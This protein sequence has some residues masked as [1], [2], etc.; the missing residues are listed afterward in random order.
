MTLPRLVT[1]PEWKQFLRLG[2]QLL[3]RSSAAA[4]ADL[5]QETLHT[6][7]GADAILWLEQPFFPLPG[8]P[9]VRLYT[10]ENTP[11][12]VSRV[13]ETHQLQCRLPESQRT[14][15]LPAD[16]CPGEV[17]VPL[18]TQ[19]NLL[20]ILHISRPHGPV[21]RKEEVNFLEALASHAALAMQ[22]NRQVVLK[23]WRYEQIALVSSV[24]TQIAN[25]MEVDEL[26]RR[27]TSLIQHTFDY[28]YVTIFTLTPQGNALEFRASAGAADEPSVPP[29]GAFTIGQ[30]L[31][32]LVA[33]NGEE[34]NVPDVR[35]DDRYRKVDSLPET[36][37]EIALPIKV[38]NRILGVLDVQSTQIH[39]FHEVDA[40]VLRALAASIAVAFEG[41][42]LYNDLQRRVDQI[43]TVFEISHALNSILDPDELL[44]EIAQTIHRRFNF[45]FVH[46]F[47]V[48][49]GRRLIFY[50]TGSGERSQAFREQ[51]VTY[52]LDAADGIIPWV[53][54]EGKTHL[55]NDTSED[56]L[57]RPSLLPPYD[58]RSELA[59][60]L[61]FGGEINGVLDIQSD[62]PHAFTENDR[63]LFEALAASI[64][65]AMRNA[66][67]YA[68]ERWRRQV[69]DSFKDVARM[70]SANVA[71]DQLLDSILKELEHN[72]PCELSAIWLLDE[73]LAGAGDPDPDAPLR[74]AAVHGI[75]A[76]KVLAARLD[77]TAA[78]SYLAAALGS[79]EPVI[80]TPADPFGPLGAAMQYPQDYSSIAAPLRS[81]D[82]VLGIITLAHST[83]GRYGSEARAMTSTFASYAAV[84]I[85][86]ARL[87]MQAQE[88]A[89]ISTVL[90][91]VAEASQS[92]S[93]LD[94]LLST[95]VRLAPLLIG[96]RKCAFFLWDEPL[97]AFLLKAVY[98]IDNLPH[99][100]EF[101][102][103]DVPALQ[104]MRL[105]KTPVFIEDAARDLQIPA[106][107]AEGAGTVI[108]LP[109]LARGEILGSFL[110]T[111]QNADPTGAH[112]PFDNQ[113]LSI[114]QGIAHQTA[115]A[116]ENIRLLEARQ[117]EAYVT[118]VML[119]VAQAVVSQNELDDILDTIVH[120]LPILVGIDSTVIYLWDGPRR[121]FH[122]A[123]AFTGSHQIEERILSVPYFEGE[124]PLLDAVHESDQ[125][126]T[127]VLQDAAL[128][129]EDWCEV[130]CPPG[131]TRLTRE[132]SR[133]GN[134]LVGY[135]LSVKGENYG[136]LIAKETSVPP[137]VHDRRMEIIHGVAQQISLAI[138]NERLN[139]E[140]IS[141]ERVEREFQLAREIQR[142]FLPSHMLNLPKWEL[143][144]RWQPAREVGGDFYDFFRLEEN[145]LG[146]VISDVS[147]KG[148]PAALYM[149]V[150]RTLIRAAAQSQK[151]PARVLD[152]VNR[153]LMS[154]SVNSMFVTAVYAIL[155][156]DTGRLVYANAGHNRP[157]LL[158][159]DGGAVEQFPK[160]GIALGILDR[161]R[162]EEH[163]IHLN[164]GDTLLLY[165]DGVTESFSPE[166]DAFGENR[167]IE[168]LQDANGKNIHE[169]LQAIDAALEEF[170]Q[171][172]LASD[173]L[174]IL[175]IRALPTQD[176]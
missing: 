80:R 14:N 72:L 134:Y 79:P 85:Q 20:G 145:R 110:V 136:V 30:G 42:Q 137:A 147:D 93:G 44:N 92:A 131:G 163:E 4:Q 119:Q 151:S 167:L 103:E 2:E 74:L 139:A 78:R 111:H 58:T 49:A 61:S 15:A 21:F 69:G 143:D 175:A 51:D 129:P 138:Q 83:S 62:Q 101:I 97:Q 124:F 34:I 53:A 41:A 150:T 64:S 73:P 54:R 172:E 158:R 31:V 98:G 29:A 57:Y 6:I 106:A 89:W 48:H 67:L 159:A 23:N 109:L 59:V 102:E 156:L 3:S 25:L 40:L 146:L 149:T 113:T 17:A 176:D 166:G 82:E 19:G 123:Q 118:A 35:Q 105:L 130:A 126:I 50:R 108:M 133:A 94:E 38:E 81:A 36:L 148:M 135:P 141:R 96:V 120:L 142:T 56:P 160:G 45:P 107:A 32:G 52:D 152:R 161:A 88:Q 115:V 153:L 33:Q 168:S 24:S 43:N 91:Q 87:Y 127:C 128:P 165:T 66:S 7:L 114:L 55:C 18:L 162:L 173:D 8:E 70:L 144:V 171:G 140:M 125:P 46:V 76:E 112:Q 71:L 9:E 1:D 63:D 11:E 5:I 68:A 104:Q 22:I 90:M 13:H 99:T 39:A 86:N 169:L 117:E 154:D 100:I 84:A 75:D 121:M 164:P 95:M 27:V 12:L 65:I 116:V 10:A 26:C 122:P 77:H 47:T 28:Y 37:S 174:T 155:E 60:P 170:Q 157:L 132:H 16:V